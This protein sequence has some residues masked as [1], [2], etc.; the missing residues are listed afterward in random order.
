MLLWSGL[1][2]GDE[3]RFS[4]VGKG[5]HVLR[6]CHRITVNVSQWAKKQ[7]REGVDVLQQ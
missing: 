3:G 7:N 5:G 1:D 6:S 2:R 4:R